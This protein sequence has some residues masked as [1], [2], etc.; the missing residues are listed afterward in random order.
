MSEEGLHPGLTLCEA[1]DVL[2]DPRLLDDMRAKVEEQKAFKDRA[3]KS[4]GPLRLLPPDAEQLHWHPLMTA[5][6]KSLVSA[7]GTAEKAVLEQF[8]E[9]LQACRV[10]AREESPAAPL[11]EVPPTALP[12]RL[13]FDPNR[14]RLA[15]LDESQ[16]A[17]GRGSKK[18]L[19]FDVR[20]WQPNSSQSDSKDQK[21]ARRNVSQSALKAF[22]DD[23]VASLDAGDRRLGQ[24]DLWEAAKDHFNHHSVTRSQVLSWWKTDMPVEK[25]FRRGQKSAR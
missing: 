15:S 11:R 8:F 10:M 20:V 6:Y 14:L 25:R 1:R 22:L 9:R 18:V 21:P 13:G 16:M 3:E 4:H 23:H 5:D 12:R 7:V 17:F 2:V 19:Y 24:M